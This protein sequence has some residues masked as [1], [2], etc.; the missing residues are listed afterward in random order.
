M[1][2]D[3]PE[4]AEVLTFMT[5][6][7]DEICEGIES[8]DGDAKFVEDKWGR[9]EGGGG[10]TRALSQG[11]IFEKGGV[12]FSDVHGKVFLPQPRKVDPT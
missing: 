11:R 7:Q 8:L 10:R 9:P 1:I 4:P 6:L 3:M 12:N 5:H 2:Q